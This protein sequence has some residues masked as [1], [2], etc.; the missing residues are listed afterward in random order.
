LGGWVFKKARTG[1]L[2][3]L[4]TTGCGKRTWKEVAE[5]RKSVNDLLAA[6]KKQKRQ[7]GQAIQDNKRK[8]GGGKKKN[9]EE[10]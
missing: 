3:M 10:N 6:R 9:D 2:R 4:L 5:P 1:K 8:R 7:G